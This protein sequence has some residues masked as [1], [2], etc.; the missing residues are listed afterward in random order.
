VRVTP[1]ILSTGHSKTIAEAIELLGIDGMDTKATFQ[2]GFDHRAVWHL[3]RHGNGLGPGSGAGDQPVAQLTKRR[4]AVRNG[5][6]SHALSAG[7]DQTNLMVL[8]RPVDAHK[9]LDFCCH[10]QTSSRI[11]TDRD[12][13][14]SLYWRSKRNLLPDFRR[15]RPAGVQVLARC[16][17]HRE[18]W[19]TPGG[20]ARSDQSDSRRVHGRFKGTGS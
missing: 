9:P 11:R 17:K 10:D 16:S 8:A 19:A 20:P 4:T 3:D 14:Q 6:F 12:D 2:Q 7:I 5:A 1:V 18:N 13:R 15:G